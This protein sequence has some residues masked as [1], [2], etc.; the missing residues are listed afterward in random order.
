MTRNVA[1]MLAVFS[2]TSWS[3]RAGAQDTFDTASIKL[4]VPPGVGEARRGGCVGGPGSNDPAMIRCDGVEL[5]YLIELAYHAKSRVT[6]VQPPYLRF[7]VIAK[8]PPGAM[9]EQVSRM[10]QN[11]LADRFNLAVHRE[12]KEMPA[13]LLVVA[14]GGL[15][16]KEVADP[17]DDDSS[18]PLA[19]L[20]RIK[21]DKD[22]FPVVPPGR[23]LT[24][25][26]GDTSYLIASNYS[27]ERFA[28]LLETLLAIDSAAWRPVVDA[29]H[30]SGRYDFRVTWEAGVNGLSHAPDLSALER[31]VGLKLEQKQT[32]IEFLV[33]DHARS[34]P[35]EN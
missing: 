14:K 26:K 7:D 5:R 23:Q 13:Y 18:E 32:Q 16:A 3:Q 10:W 34:S 4:T 27:M 9:Q 21:R 8:V 22:G 6:G 12:T 29:T 31:H 28:S 24:Y 1:L 11:L 19:P 30:L 20:S 15:K 25:N 17:P 33:V 35:T 2:G